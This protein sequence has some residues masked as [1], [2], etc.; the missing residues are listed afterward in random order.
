MQNSYLFLRREV[1]V[2]NRKNGASLRRQE[3][4]LGI[5]DIIDVNLY[6]NCWNQIF[7]HRPRC[8]LQILATKPA[9]RTPLNMSSYKIL[10]TSRIK[11]NKKRRTVRAS[12]NKRDRLLS[13]S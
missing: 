8:W 11:N 13:L 12:H 5:V 6:Y 9:M 2:S 7:D 3:I 4:P 1:Y 10:F